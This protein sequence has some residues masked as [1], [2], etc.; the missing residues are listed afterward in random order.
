MG[1]EWVRALSAENMPDAEVAS[2]SV[3]IVVYQ[4]AID[5]SLDVSDGPY[6][7]DTGRLTIR[8]NDGSESIAFT[9]RLLRP[10]YTVEGP[11]SQGG[12]HVLYLPRA[13]ELNKT[14]VTQASFTVRGRDGRLISKPIVLETP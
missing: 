14:G 7:W 13:E 4:S 12:F 5:V 10:G 9:D 11:D 6:N 2:D 1:N 3:E 8:K